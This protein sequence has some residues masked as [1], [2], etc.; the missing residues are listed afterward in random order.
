MENANYS[1]LPLKV[2]DWLYSWVK[3][4]KRGRSSQSPSSKF[5]GLRMGEILARCSLIRR[6]L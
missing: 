1:K 5:I 6:S 3:S 2:S 4:A